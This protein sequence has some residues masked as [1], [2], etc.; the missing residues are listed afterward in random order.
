MTVTQPAVSPVPGPTPARPCYLILCFGFSAKNLRKQPWYTVDGIAR[1]LVAHGVRVVVLSDAADP[2]QDVPYAVH[3]T[4]RRRASLAR[5]GAELPRLVHA[6]RADRV[7]AVVG[8]AELA[9]LPHLKAGVPVHALVASPRL[10]LG[11]VLQ[12]PL[13]AWLSEWRLVLRPL[14]NAL[15]PASLLDR[16]VRRSGLAGL[17]WLGAETRER[18]T[19]GGLPAGPLLVP[20][21]VP[22]SLP[23]P[24]QAQVPTLGFFGPPLWVRGLDLVLDVFIE[25][26]QRGQMLRL[27]LVLRPDRG[28]LPHWLRRRLATCAYARDIELV[29]E[30]LAPA[31][32]ARALADIDVFLLPFRIPVSEA[33][34][35]VPEAALS[36]R[37]VVV[38]DRPGVGSWARQLGGLA[39]ATPDGLADA[40]LAALAMPPKV[41]PAAWSD[42]RATTLSL[43]PEHLDVQS[44]L[45]RLRLL[46]LCGPDGS[47]KTTLAH[48][49]VNRLA[50]RGV[51]ARYLWSRYRNYL[52][53]P[54]LG[55][56]RLVGLSRL[57]IRA[58]VRVR[59]R[60][61]R[62]L[63]GL[64]LLFL[65][66]QTMDQAIEILLRLRRP[67]TVVAD[68]C[69]YDTL[70]DLALETG[71]EALVLNWIGPLLHRLLPQPRVVLLL[72]RDPAEIL[73]DRPDVAADPC[74]EE[75][76][77]LYA[78]VAR[79]FSLKPVRVA[80]TAADLA[81]AIECELEGQ[82][83]V[84]AVSPAP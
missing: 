64:A 21:V 63:P 9:R 43:L 54:L 71:H 14:A 23:P 50:R 17:I 29:H 35:V 24:R 58:G 16:A 48:A 6:F 25:L 68:R 44:Q 70:V 30:Q 2:P 36:G 66:L 62:R 31:A 77:R 1:G 39:V 8:L 22:P 80:G 15:L 55:L 41:A 78:E 27:R 53:K 73:R 61:F 81:R 10:R 33:P 5:I 40:V 37:P 60:D 67:G 18:L 65:F 52:S 20:G 75:R 38:L 56:M 11:E 13:A 42:W 69:L 83:R 46:A 82:A 32:L 47:G 76:R 34:L 7:L 59:D 72:E 3:L 19:A 74:F 28:E 49:L 84:L 4:D 57:Q 12:L 79:R 26:R 51:P 45:W